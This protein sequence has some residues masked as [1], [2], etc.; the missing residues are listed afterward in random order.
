MKK[1]KTINRK[2]YKT[3]LEIGCF[4]NELFDNIK[5]EKK[6][7][8]DPYSGGTIRKTSDDFFL[9][10]KENFDIIF[11]DGLHRYHQVKQDILNSLILFQLNLEPLH[12]DLVESY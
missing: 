2:K 4:H 3:Y 10:N 11:I 12:V 5:C 1:R 8:V 7:G 9:S 6:V